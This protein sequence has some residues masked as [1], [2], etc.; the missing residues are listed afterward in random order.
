MPQRPLEEIGLGRGTQSV[1][2]ALSFFPFVGLVIGGSYW[3]RKSIA[4][5]QLGRQLFMF[6]LVL[7]T[8]YLFCVCP[9]LIAFA[10]SR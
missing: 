6:T 1:L 4:T 9:A 2:Y 5:R 8:L 10:A 7:H 3:M